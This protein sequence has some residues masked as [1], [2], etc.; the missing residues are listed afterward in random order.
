ML[1]LSYK[2]VC[3]GNDGT[4]YKLIV[5]RILGNEFKV[6][7]WSAEFDAITFQQ[8]IN[9]SYG[10]R[11]VYFL[12]KNLKIFTEDIIADTDD[13]LLIK[14]CLPN[15]TILASHG[16]HAKQAICINNDMSHLAIYICGW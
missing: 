15:H 5:V 9:N 14:E 7:M 10:K 11:V 3:T 8:S 1:I 2:I 13:V 4:I 12:S 6:K 16:Y